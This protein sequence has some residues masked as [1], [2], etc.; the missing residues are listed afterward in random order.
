MSMDQDPPRLLDDPELGEAMRLLV[1]DEPSPAID[2]RIT[3]AITTGPS[4]FVSWPRWLLGMSVLSILAMS[5]GVLGWRFW[6]HEASTAAHESASLEQPQAA[7]VPN[8]VAEV[9]SEHPE[10]AT[11]SDT[12][13]PAS[14]ERSSST[15]QVARPSEEQLILDARRSLTTNP[16]RTESRLALHRRLYPDGLLAEEREALS[17]ELWIHEGHMERARRALER[18]RRRHPDSA[19]VARLE[20]L[21]EAM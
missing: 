2:A 8:P 20:R 11:P 4:R 3:N 21:L 12:P 10:Q 15:P 13:I 9:H 17:I 7:L 16:S 14:E 5:G 19:H 1:S 18:I 6:R